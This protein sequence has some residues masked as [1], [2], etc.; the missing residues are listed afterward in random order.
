MKKHVIKAVAALAGASLF[1]G[2]PAAHAQW[3]GAGAGGVGTDLNTTGNWTGG[4]VNGV[5]TGN[6]STA[7]VSLSGD[8]SVASLNFQWATTGIGLTLGGTGTINLSGNV[9]LPQVSQNPETVTLSSGVTL[10]LGSISTLRTFNDNNLGTGRLVIDGLLTGTA[11]GSGSI[12]FGGTSANTTITLNNTGNT[13]DAPIRVASGT[14]N[15]ASIGN[16]GGG[17]S[18]LGSASTVANG[19]ITLSRNSVLAY[20]GSTNQSSDRALV[21]T[22]LSAG[23]VLIQHKGTGGT[24]T[25]ASDLAFG[26]YSGE[27]RTAAATG[28]KLVFNGVISNDTGATKAVVNY[29]GALGTT[30]FGNVG[31]TY[32]GYTQIQTGVLEVT[33]LAAGGVASGIGQ[34]SNVAAN[35]IIGNNGS[36]SATLRYLGAGDST[37]RLFS[38]TGAA[39]GIIDS[40]GTGALKFTNTGAVAFGTINLARKLTLTGSSTA[41][42]TLAVAIG[43]NG[44]GKTSFTKLGAGKWTITG[45]NTFTGATTVSEGTLLVNGSLTSAVT[46]TAGMF[47]GSGSTTGNVTIGTSTGTRDAML[48]AGAGAGAFTTTGAL[49]FK[50]DGELVFTFNSTLGTGGSVTANGVTI[51]NAAYFTFADVG[52]GSGV[53]L[54]QSFV[55]LNNSGGSSITGTFV[56]L[57][58]DGTFVSNGVTW[59]ASYD[60]GVGG[61]DLVLTAIAVSSVPEPG[62]FALIMGAIGLLGASVRRVRRNVS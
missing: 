12:Q 30:V 35:L 45:T 33:K 50:A 29:N 51:N 39:G 49:E 37:D 62:S 9:L 59:R 38:L 41:D 5:F 54:N 42:N 25:Y 13:F 7:S 40:S 47:G 34:S 36:N 11:S 61:N 22:S 32:G 53:T 20:T 16:V 18:A 48:S 3:I 60:G 28:T 23:P 10:A 58:D 27:F 1:F 55:V 8:I 6:T 4:T 19:T 21:F 15:F 24:L 56:N 57:A 31:N 46:V 52:N 17:A 14:L 44:T 43:D 26:A 2:L